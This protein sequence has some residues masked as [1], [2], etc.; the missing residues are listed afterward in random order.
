MEQKLSIWL[1]HE[2]SHAFK[3]N[4]LIDDKIN[5]EPH[6]FKLSWLNLL[7]TRTRSDFPWPIFPSI[8]YQLTQSI[9]C[10]PLEIKLEKFYYTLILR[11]WSAPGEIL[12]VW[13]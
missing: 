7:V 9:S 5:G 8:N 10:F 3:S 4:W 11:D 6:Y 13:Q 1:R 2:I 12:F